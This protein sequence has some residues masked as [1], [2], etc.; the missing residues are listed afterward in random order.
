MR[1]AQISCADDFIRELPD[2]LNTVI[3]ERGQ[4]LSEGQVQRIAIA[5]AILTDA[6]VLILDEA[7]SAL[8]EETEKRLLQNIK[9]LNHK[10]CIIVSH[11]KAAESVCN[12]HLRIAGGKIPETEMK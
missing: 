11:K 7:T 12:R 5:R 6:P 3:G 2:G 10:T 9:G 4:G 1:A 8:D